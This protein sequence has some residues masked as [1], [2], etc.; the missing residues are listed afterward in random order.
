M[1]EIFNQQNVIKLE[2][3]SFHNFTANAVKEIPA[4]GK[5]SVTILFA[6]DTKIKQLNNQFRERNSPT[7]VL[8]FPNETDDFNLDDEAL[9]EIIISVEQANRQAIENNLPLELEI[10]QLILHGILHL[11]GFDHETDNGEMNELELQLREKLN[12]NG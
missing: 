1:I 2:P 8:S 12:I 6:S 7:D 4:N 10:K 3:L 9:G 11:C 5:K